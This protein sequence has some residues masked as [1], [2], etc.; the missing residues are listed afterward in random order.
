M[1]LR[2]TKDVRDDPLAKDVRDDPLAKEG[3]KLGPKMGATVPRHPKS[4]RTQQDRTR[5]TVDRRHFEISK[6]RV[7]RGFARIGGI[8]SST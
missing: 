1:F 8:V 2:R 3:R 6:Q 7:K 5:N 4:G